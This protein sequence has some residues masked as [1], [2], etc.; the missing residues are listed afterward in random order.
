MNR[1]KL[2]RIFAIAKL[3][4]NDG[5]LLKNKFINDK[6]DEIMALTEEINNDQEY[7]F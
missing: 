1:V 2:Y 7:K 4:K 5:E 6:L 3:L